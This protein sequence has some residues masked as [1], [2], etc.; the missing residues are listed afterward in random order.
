MKYS[1]VENKYINAG[2]EEHY[3]FKNAHEV[4][5]VLGFNIKSI[6]GFNDL[7]EEDQ[8]LAEILICKFINGWGLEA[9]EKL[10][11]PTKILRGN[12][13]FIL[14]FKDDFYYLFDDGSV[15]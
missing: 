7:S 11:S 4:S 5:L 6:K 10:S 1:D 13:N 14:T 2:I 12:G 15:G 8:D 9:R 3:K